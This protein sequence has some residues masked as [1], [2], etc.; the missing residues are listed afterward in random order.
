MIH[1][2]YLIIPTRVGTR[3]AV[4]LIINTMN[5]IATKTKPLSPLEALLSDKTYLGIPKEGDMIKGK[6]VSIA[7]NEIRIDIPGFR[8]GVVRGREIM[9]NPSVVKDYHVGD[10]VEATVVDLENEAGDVELSFR[11]AGARRSWDQAATFMGSGTAMP[12]KIIEANKGGLMVQAGSMLGFLPVSQLAP[13]H[14]PRVQGGDK[15]KILERLRDLVG[16]EIRAKVIDVSEAENKLIF[17]E[18]AVWEDE[19]RGELAKFK[20]GDVVEGEVTALTD[21]GAFVKFANLEGLVHI[22]EIAWQRIDHPRDVLAV[23]QKVKASVINLQGSKIFLSVKRL[24]DDPWTALAEKYKVGQVV[25]G[26]IVKENPFGFFVELDPEIQGLAHISELSTTPV[27]S[28]TEVAHV[29]DTL[30][31]KIVSIEPEQHRLGL[32]LKALKDTEPQKEEPSQSQTDELP[33]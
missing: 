8:T 1:S 11:G 4:G 21:F 31:W 30:E 19:Q 33:N 9:E 23:G 22:S 24:T 26:K 17:S 18:K 28:P 15:G 7:R 14:Y 3:H 20:V 32:S 13:E 16:T 6:I 29:G 25:T 27:T 5:D 2:P 12:V 10:E